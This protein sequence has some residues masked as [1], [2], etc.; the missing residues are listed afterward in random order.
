M[1][2]FKNFIEV[3]D[4][5][6]NKRLVNVNAIVCAEPLNEDSKNFMDNF[7]QVFSTLFSD[8]FMEYYKDNGIDDEASKAIAE[9]KKVGVATQK[10]KTLIIVTAP[11]E[12]S[13]LIFALETY[14][15]IKNMIKLA[16]LGAI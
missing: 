13:R 15:T 4:T 9:I 6:N 1:N 2:C 11:T 3:T 16:T 14:D 12:S 5:D 10:A 8:D 7:D